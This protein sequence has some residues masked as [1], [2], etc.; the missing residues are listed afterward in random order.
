MEHPCIKPVKVGQQVENFSLETYIPTDFSFGQISLEQLKKQGKWT[1]LVFY[2][3]DFTFVCSTEL[4]DFADRYEEFKAAGAELITVSTDTQFTH[5]AW[6]REE[7]SLEKAK[8]LMAADPTGNVSK[9]FDVYDYETGLAL[10][11][12]FII[13]PEGMIVASEVNY[14]NV[15]RSAAETLRKL[16]ASIYVAKHPEQACPANWH[17]GEKTLTPSADLVGKVYDALK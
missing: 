9:M 15:G 17:E 10:R 1:V 7:K 14:Y 13:N 12:T 6:K 4:A 8:Y 11:G 3:A 2:P 16:K 5:L